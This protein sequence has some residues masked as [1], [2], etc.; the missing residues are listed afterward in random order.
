[1]NKQLALRGVYKRVMA[2]MFLMAVYL[3]ITFCNPAH[4]ADDNNKFRGI[5]ISP[6]SRSFDLRNGQV[7]VGQMSVENSTDSVM[8]VQM[9][10]GS[11]EILNDN[12]NTPNYDRPSKYSAIANWIKLDKQDLQIQ[13]GKS[14]VINYTI[15][16]PSN[17]P[18]GTQYA[19]IFASN[20]PKG[21]GAGIKA[22]SRVGMVI[23]ARM[24]DGK[25]I[26]A[27]SIKNEKID[28]YQPTSPLKAIFSV[29]N[30][31]NVGSDVAYS[32]MIKNAIN[33]SE[34]YRSAQKTDSIFPET[35]RNM[36]IGW[37]KV[38]VGFY[39]V[40]LTINLNG[41]VHTVKKLVCTVPI[42]III[43]LII[44]IASLTAYGVIN[45]RMAKESRLSTTKKT[46][47]RKK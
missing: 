20:T 4:A 27:S 43:L 42:W 34:V 22:T 3:L 29:K 30:E 40:E 47:K 8:H 46:N 31:G 28:W 17:P 39:N 5:L 26:D 14:E 23:R 32:L 6:A 19:T 18:G 24:V 21:D 16:T 44:A 33:G 25:T 41:R 37:D 13:P 35:T 15:K 11:Y 38:G 1:M 2:A 10:V 9:S 12:Y 7:Y 45:Y 36:S